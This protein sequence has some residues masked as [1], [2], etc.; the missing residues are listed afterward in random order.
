[1]PKE[2]E[3]KLRMISAYL[4]LEGKKKFIIPE[5][6]RSYSWTTEA[7]DKLWQDIEDFMNSSTVND[8]GEKEPYFFGT[9]IADCSERE[10]V[11]LID[12]QQRSTTFILL[13]KALLL[14]ILEELKTITRDDETE[15]LI[16]ALEDR[17]NAIVDILSEIQKK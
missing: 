11:C 2:I 16:D 12:G 14:R 10:N 3:P 15:S 9:I 7:C 4:K 6:Q 17:R 8:S 5:Y 13:M 1:M